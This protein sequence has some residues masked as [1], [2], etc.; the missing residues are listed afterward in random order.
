MLLLCV[1]WMWGVGHPE[2]ST[3]LVMLP[4]PPRA[5]KHT[6]LHPEDIQFFLPYNLKFLL[7]IF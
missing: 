1:K 6:C 7:P 4:A 2:Q 5:R 3:K